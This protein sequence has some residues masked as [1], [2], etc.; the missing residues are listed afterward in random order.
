MNYGRGGTMVRNQPLY[1]LYFAGS[2]STTKIQR[3]SMKE[4]W[5]NKLMQ[6]KSS[7]KNYSK[8]FFF[9]AKRDAPIICL[10]LSRCS[11]HLAQTTSF[12]LAHN[13]RR[14]SKH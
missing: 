5:M 12:K 2:M 13:L 4:P 6:S 10:S 7:P 1:V 8:G 3:T 11:R 14:G 9:Q